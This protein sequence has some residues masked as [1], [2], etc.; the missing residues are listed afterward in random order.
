MTMEYEW[1]I[2]AEDGSDP[3]P[4]IEQMLR[5]HDAFK[6]YRIE[7][8]DDKAA[9]I[10]FGTMPSQA[11]SRPKSERKSP[12]EVELKF[13]EWVRKK[14]G[15]TD[16]E[17]IKKEAHRIYKN[18]MRYG[19]AP[20][21]F[22]RP[23]MYVALDEAEA[24]N[25]NNPYLDSHT[26]KDLADEIVELMKRYIDTNDTIYTGTLRNSIMEPEE[27]AI[28]SIGDEDLSILNRT[29]DI[30]DVLWSSRTAGVNP[31]RPPGSRYQETVR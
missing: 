16:E 3:V 13:R 5:E 6:P 7:V 27:I 15:S 25:I 20:I 31:N 26:T 8:A 17:W 12:T 23:A 9:F 2:T 14:F 28:E 4:V 10:E 21:P 24:G 22:M 1:R 18:I 19:M 30:D 29:S 11:P